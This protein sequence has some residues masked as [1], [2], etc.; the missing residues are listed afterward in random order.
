MLK[1][2]LLELDGA[3]FQVIS[4]GLEEEDYLH[5]I[6]FREEEIEDQQLGYSVNDEGESLIGSGEGDWRE[7]WIVIGYEEDLGDPLIVDTSQEA[8][9][10]FTAEHGAGDWEPILLF[11][12]LQNIKE[13][14]GLK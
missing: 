13:R 8:M 7:G 10:V 1:P 11:D 4:K 3:E 14:I 9:P 6:L 5:F 2:F 12:S